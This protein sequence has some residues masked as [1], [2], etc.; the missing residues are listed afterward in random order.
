MSRDSSVL[1]LRDSGYP[2]TEK[3]EMH[4]ITMITLDSFN[5]VHFVNAFPLINETNVLPFPKI[6][7]CN[8]P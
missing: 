3:S 2:S 7:T 5:W 1:E 6:N 8:I 4:V